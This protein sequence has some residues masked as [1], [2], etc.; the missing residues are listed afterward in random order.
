MNYR[1]C[2]RK[3]K[4]DIVAAKCYWVHQCTKGLNLFTILRVIARKL[5]SMYKMIVF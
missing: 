4:L 3:T 5:E 1:T 2:T